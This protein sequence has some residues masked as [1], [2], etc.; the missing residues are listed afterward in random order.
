MGFVDQLVRDFQDSSAWLE[1]GALLACL[2]F[3]YGLA[4]TLWQRHTRAEP[5]RE[6]VWFGRG[7]FSG[8]ILPVLALVLVSIA[9]AVIGHYQTVF[10]LRLA[11][12]LLLSLAVIRLVARVLTQTF[13][14]STSMRLVERLFSWMAWGV[15]V[16]GSLGLLPA[17]MAELEAVHFSVGKTAVNLLTLIEGLLVAAFMVVGV[18]WFSA[19][20]ERRVL[21]QLVTDLSMRKVGMNLLR[22]VLIT[23]GLLIVLSVVGV[24]L[25]A[26]SVLGGALGVGLGFGMQKI[27]SNYVS[28]FLVLIERALRIGD[29]VR[30]NGFEGRITDIKTRFTV[31]RA[32]NGREAIVPNETLITQP[33]ENLTASDRRFSLSTN[34]VV[35][36]NCDVGQVQRILV[37]AAST[38]HPRVLADPAPV[39][40]LLNVLAHGLEFSLI[41]YIED[42]N[43]GQGG[44]RSAVNIAVLQGLRNAHIPLALPS[45]VLQVQNTALDAAISTGEGGAP[46]A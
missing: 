24:D 32:S 33:V 35:P 3:A 41:Y 18:L 40:L 34:V 5:G 37:E 4:R 14:N 39:A 9:Q 28:G 21:S 17:V 7:V 20:F 1:L 10:W 36:L 15:A 11:G 16:L 23:V 12:S 29:N 31:I 44:I 6:T 43:N 26:L 25:T 30:V 38:A 46:A 2:L 45:Q 13:P 22:T 27:A 19:T 8:G 42:P